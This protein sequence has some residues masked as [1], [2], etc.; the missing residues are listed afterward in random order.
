MDY[1]GRSFAFRDVYLRPGRRRVPELPHPV[2]RLQLGAGA[3]LPGPVQ[4]QR[5]EPADAA[6]VP[7]ML[8]QDRQAARKARPGGSADLHGAA[9]DQHV[10]SG[11][12]VHVRIWRRR[13]HVF[14]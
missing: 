10:S 7:G 6:R 12:R 8:R 2:L 3:P 5:G 1:L 9:A 11:P 13:P 14:L 4:P